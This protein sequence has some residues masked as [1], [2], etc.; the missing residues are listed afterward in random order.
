MPALRTLVDADMAM[1]PLHSMDMGNAAHVSESYAVSIFN[2]HHADGS[3]IYLRNVEKS[4]LI[5][6]WY[7][8]PTG[9]YHWM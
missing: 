5:F 4:C 3:S 8:N 9:Y 2:E 6:T 1:G 7:R